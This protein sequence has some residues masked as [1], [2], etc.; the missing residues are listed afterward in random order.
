MRMG[1]LY[2][3]MDGRVTAKRARYGYVRT[4]PKDTH[5]ALHPEESKIVRVIFEKVIYEGETLRQIT[6]WLNDSGIPTKY[7]GKAGT[8]AAQ[9]LYRLITSPVYKGEYYAHR[10][11]QVKVGFNAKGKPKGKNIEHP[12]EEWIKVDVPAIVTPEE[13]DMAQGAMKK[14]AKRSPRNAGKRDWLLVGFLKCGICKEYGYCAQMGNMRTSPRRYYRCNSFGSEKAR[15]F[16]TNC[17]SPSVHAD[18]L[19]RRVWEEIMKVIYDP[20]IV[21]RRLEEKEKEERRMGHE[22][23]IA[24]IDSQLAEL[25]KEKGKFEA[26]Y[27]RDIYTLDEFEEKMKDL[28]GRRESLEISRAKLQSRL[29]ETHSIE[30]QRIIV[31]AALT[32][33]RKEVD[34]ARQ[35]GRLPDEIPFDLK[36]RILS[37]LVDVIYVDSVTRTFTIEGEIKGTYSLDDNRE[38]ESGG[39]TGDFGYG[40]AATTLQFSSD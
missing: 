7:S 19:E 15:R 3:A 20:G 23:Q 38:S 12:P 26:A 8:W 11:Y 24:F 17:D 30:E 25:A 9:T 21:I 32:R 28:R 10:H 33:I 27:K 37:M 34:L 39:Q 14:N 18:L 36:R 4:D 29:D 16:K 31:I 1:N 40:S 6:K 2:K 5:Y 35:Q 13:W 22:E